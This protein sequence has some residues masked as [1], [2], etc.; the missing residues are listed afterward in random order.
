MLMHSK[1]RCEQILNSYQMPNDF[2]VAVVR[3][4]NFDRAIRKTTVMQDNVTIRNTKFVLKYSSSMFVI[5]TEKSQLD[6]NTCS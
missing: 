5:V 1:W 3:F 2:F 6:R 4:L